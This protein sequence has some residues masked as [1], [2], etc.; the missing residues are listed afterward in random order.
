MRGLEPPT[1]GLRIRYSA[2]LSYIPVLVD[3]AR[4]ELAVYGLKARCHT[5]WLQ[6]RKMVSSVGY[7]PT[8]SAL[9][10]DASTRLA[11]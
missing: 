2:K 1:F 5:T 10:A 9:Q 4:L 7:D 6:I 3:P 8:P 11:Y